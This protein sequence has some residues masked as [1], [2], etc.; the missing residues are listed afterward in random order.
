MPTEWGGISRDQALLDL[1]ADTIRA[2]LETY[3]LR[4]LTAGAIADLAGSAAMAVAHVLDVAMS[5]PTDPVGLM[6]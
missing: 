5:E 2:S 1:I 6:E 3:R 4:P